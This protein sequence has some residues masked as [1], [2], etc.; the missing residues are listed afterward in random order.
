MMK[1]HADEKP[2]GLNKGHEEEVSAFVEL[3]EERLAEIGEDS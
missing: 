3:L 2:D 1:G